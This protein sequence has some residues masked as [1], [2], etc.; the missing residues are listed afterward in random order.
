MVK[1][2]ILYAGSSGIDLRG[3]LKKIVGVD[4]ESW[5]KVGRYDKQWILVRTAMTTS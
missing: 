5:E 1:A 2:I 3:S 4:P